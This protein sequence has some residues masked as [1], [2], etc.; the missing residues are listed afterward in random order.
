MGVFH[1]LRDETGA[2]EQLASLVSKSFNKGKLAMREGFSRGEY[3]VQEY[4]LSWYRKVNPELLSDPKGA[5]KYVDNDYV[6][7]GESQYFWPP[8]LVDLYARCDETDA[9]TASSLWVP[10]NVWHSEGLVGIMEALQAV[11]GKGAHL[12][13]FRLCKKACYVNGI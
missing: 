5:F 7:Y 12:G 10:K 6:V 8:P 3:D 4:F 1:A 2:F 11:F 13:A 9:S